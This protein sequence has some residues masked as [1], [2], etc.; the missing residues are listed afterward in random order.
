MSLS[1]ELDSKQDLTK[2][3]TPKKKSLAKG[4]KVT[5]YIWK[6]KDG[7]GY[8]IDISMA[9]N[10]N[11]R[12]RA[13]RKT[14]GEAKHYRDT[15]REKWKANPEWKPKQVRAD[16]RRLSE[17]IDKWYDL[18]GKTLTDGA[19]RR[20][21]LRIAVTYMD[22]PIARQFDKKM[23][24]DYRNKRLANKIAKKTINNEHGYLVSLFN[25]L[26][27]LGHWEHKNP[28]AN[29]PKFKLSEPELSYLE[30][31]EYDALLTILKRLDGEVALIAETCL[32]TGA[33]WSEVQNLQSRQVK[34]GMVYLTQTKTKK[35]RTV[36]ISEDLEERLKQRAK[37]GRI[38]R[39][40]RCEKIFE[41]AILEAGIE[42]PDGQLTH[43]L[44]HT[45]ATH[46]LSNGMDI[47][48]L[49]DILGHT[50]IK[51]TERYLH[52]VRSRIVQTDQLN[53]VAMLS[54][55]AAKPELKIV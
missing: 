47:Y 30:E 41:R 27:N 25:E 23:L 44:R 26:H 36:K 35:N 4:T 19:R 33:R 13:R 51:T 5:E 31:H 28:I 8:I 7:Q 37:V 22:N 16:N 14:L 32:S 54:K 10:K 9:G 3:P 6:A 49:K 42:L 1:T 34:N 11:E 55:K 52:I 46:A 48:Q 18:Y 20:N 17:L 53:P 21:K 15:V 39:K 38:F 45:F 50:S 2:K 29:V 12:T 43:V 24:A 40:E